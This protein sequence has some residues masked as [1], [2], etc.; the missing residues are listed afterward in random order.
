MDEVR[1]F[2]VWS[3]RIRSNGLKLVRRK[4]HTNVQKNFF[5]VRVKEHWNKLPR[6]V[7]DSPFMEMFKILLD[8]Y[9]CDLLQGTFCRVPAGLDSGISW[10]PF[11]PLQFCDSVIW[12]P[13]SQGKRPFSA[14]GSVFLVV[15][16]WNWQ[17][18]LLNIDCNSTSKN[19]MCVYIYVY[20]YI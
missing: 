11:Q 14:A 12:W 8:A 7:V 13:K 6:E 20:I 4:F 17:L 19:S 3:A 2:L 18:V 5:T 15:S 9:L 1:L 10:G 16:T